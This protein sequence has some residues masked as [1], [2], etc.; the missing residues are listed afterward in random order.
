MLMI[1]L[2][3]FA[4]SGG[5]FFQSNALAGLNYTAESATLSGTD[6]VE[7]SLILA[8]AVMLISSKMRSVIGLCCKERALVSMVVLAVASC[9][10]SQFP[11]LSLVASIYLA[12]S[13]LFAFYLYRR[14]SPEQLPELLL[15][16]GW[17]CL[18][19]SI[20]L[21]LF[22]PTYGL[23]HATIGVAGWRG[24]YHKKNMCA[25]MT[26]FLLS[27]AFFA[28]TRGVFSKLLRV[29]YIGLSVLVIWM[30]HSATGILLLACL[31]IYVISLKVFEKF[32]EKD[33]VVIGLFATAVVMLL[34]VA[35]ISYWNEIIYLLGKDPTLTGRTQIWQAIWVSIVKR[36]LLG[37]GYMA[38]WRGLE[39]ESAN[40]LLANG[41]AVT[42]AHNGYLNIW[43]ML[44]AA[45]LGLVLYSLL[46]S[47]KD[48]ALCLRSR[49][50]SHVRWYA[51]IVLL[52]VVNNVDENTLLSP[53][54]LFWILYIIAS[55]GLSEETRRIRLGTDN[56]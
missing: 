4:S 17:V 14:F 26:L 32:R 27:G 15:M 51:C 33:S 41:W 56:G 20:L 53:N 47:I 38:F 16:I 30:A 45:G 31:S 40:I 1:P 10:W 12:V 37:Y 5:L 44:G 23:D 18:I 8:V 46:R 48:A 54:N 2:F 42:S 25:N 55:V 49:R 29:V 36:P 3:F 11:R 43:L 13:T 7:Y 22:L 39:G 35:G 9:A 28:P 24:I 21:V 6:R 34:V 19:S 52:M 50:S